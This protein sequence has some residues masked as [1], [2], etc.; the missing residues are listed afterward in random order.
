MNREAILHA[1]EQTVERESRLFKD[2]QW[3]YK[4]LAQHNKLFPDAPTDG[5]DCEIAQ[6]E[7]SLR[8][9]HLHITQLIKLLIS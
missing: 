8:E 6:L 2:L 5:I 4:H 3:W 9:H 7:A 1:L